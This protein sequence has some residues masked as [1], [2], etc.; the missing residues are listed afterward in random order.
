MSQN[1]AK[2]VFIIKSNR[3]KIEFPK[4]EKGREGLLFIFAGNQKKFLRLKKRR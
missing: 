4:K 1:K 2:S 3:I